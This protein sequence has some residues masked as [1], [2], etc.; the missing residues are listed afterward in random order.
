MVGKFLF[1]TATVAQLQRIAP[2]FVHLTAHGPE[3]RSVRWTP[4]D[5]IQVDVGKLTLWT[6]TPFAWDPA[7]GTL[8]LLVYVREGSFRAVA[9]AAYVS[10]FSGRAKSIQ[11][12][13]TGLK[14]T[15]YG[16]EGKI[17]ID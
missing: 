10:V 3:L 14:V 17:G 7:L 11:R 6:Y 5:E 13:R 1:R 8:Q 15:A 16:A 4:G 9:S 2:G 12:L